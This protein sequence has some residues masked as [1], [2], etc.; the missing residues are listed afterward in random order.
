MNIF[1]TVSW[2]ILKMVKIV[3]CMCIIKSNYIVSY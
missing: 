2:E 1:S 3:Q